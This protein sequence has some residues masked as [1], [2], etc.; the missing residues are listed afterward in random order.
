M[1][2]QEI[3]Q[4]ATALRAEITE[5]NRRYHELD[6]PIISDAEYDELVRELRALEEEFPEL[7]TPDSPTQQVG[8][9]PQP[10]CSPRSMHAVPMMSLD[11]AFGEDELRAWVERL[12]RRLA[13]APAASDDEPADEVGYVCELKIDG[14]AISIRY[15]GG[16]Y[17]RAATRG[18]G[19]TGEDVTENVRTIGQIPKSLGQGRARRCSRCGARSTCRCR[20]SGRST[21]ARSQPSCGRS[22]TPATPRR[23]RCARR[24]PASPPSASWPCGRTSWAR[25]RAGRPSPA[26]TRRSTGWGRSASR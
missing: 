7:I 11:N 16:R 17:V 1:A 22:S 9:R 3:E 20:P 15:E 4:R 25:S 10:R 26:T 6:D 5:H 13:G 2:D 8:G 19:R 21:S 12:H 14:L 23:A 24:T 18:D